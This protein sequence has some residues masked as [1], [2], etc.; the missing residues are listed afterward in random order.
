MK[1]KIC[2]RCQQKKAYKTFYKDTTRRD[3]L[4]N[5][6]KACK[7]SMPSMRRGTVAYFVK[8][9]WHCLNKRTVNGRYPDLDNP[10]NASYFENGIRLEMTRED[11]KAFCKSHKAT[12][13]KL[14][15]QGKTPSV[16]RIDSHK[17]YSIDN[18][19]I[20]SLD[21]NIRRK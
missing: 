11:F 10:K 20:I 7:N 14:Y 12:I 8:Q 2:S 18:I 6:C 1:R 13:S 9:S 3:G 5:T 16:D 19:Q 4:S 17:H 15:K 21:E